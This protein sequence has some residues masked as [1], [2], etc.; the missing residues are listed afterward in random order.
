MKIDSLIEFAMSRNTEKLSLEL[1]YAYSGHYSFP[2]FF[3]TSS[4]LK[5]LVVEGGIMDTIPTGTTVSWTSLLIP[6]LSLCAEL[7]LLD[8]SKSL[9]L[10]RLDIQGLVP[11]QIV[12]PHVQFLR[13]SHSD[14]SQCDFSDPETGLADSLQVMVLKTLEKLQN[15]EK[16]TLCGAFFLQV[17]VSIPTL[18]VEALTFETLLDQ[19]IIPGIAKMLQNSPRLK[20]L[21]LQIDD[22]CSTIE[23]CSLTNYLHWKSLC[24][25][26]CWKPK[27]VAL[28]T[29]SEPKLMT[30]FMKF[31]LRNTGDNCYTTGSYTFS[32][33]N[34]GEIS[35]VIDS[36]QESFFLSL[37]LIEHFVILLFRG[38][39]S[40][41][42]ICV[43]NF[44]LSTKRLM[45]NYRKSLLTSFFC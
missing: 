24:T 33:N 1:H 27:D 10:K 18:K 39:L 34:N 45:Q 25:R 16:L 40:N 8:L 35:F 42:V 19:S 22:D 5:Q 36:T 13:L 4:S 38:S 31:L 41:E 15:V 3:Y 32:E 9:Q 37:D 26:Q 14:E 2:D 20:K 44:F 7:E 28:E 23:E 6:S 11:T 21:K 17:S 29:W 30:S 12:A 43:W